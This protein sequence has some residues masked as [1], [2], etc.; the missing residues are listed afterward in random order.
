LVD[1]QYY[2]LPHEMQRGEKG[3][4]EAVRSQGLL[5]A[6][7]GERLAAVPALKRMVIFDTGQSGTTVAQA[8]R[9]R[10]RLPSAGHR[11]AEPLRRAFTLA[12]LA[13]SQRPK[14]CRS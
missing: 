10:N 4:D 13:V 14:R 3:L 12:A 7:L 8:K 6:E 1:K 9:S 2:F 5:A 11:A